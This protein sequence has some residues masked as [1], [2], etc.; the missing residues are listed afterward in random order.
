MQQK[1]ESE[2]CLG[3]ARY[4]RLSGPGAGLVGFLTRE[5]SEIVNF[6][7][8]QVSGLVPSTPPPFPNSVGVYGSSTA[9][10]QR[11][12]YRAFLATGNSSDYCASASSRSRRQLVTMLLPKAS[13]VLVVI[14]D[15]TTVRMPDVVVS[16]PVT[17]TGSSANGCDDNQQNNQQQQQT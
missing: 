6:L 2:V 8:N 7:G 16:V 9:A 15:A 3:L 13:S 14:A 4:S 5:L 11:A 10:C 12:D 1:P 17:A